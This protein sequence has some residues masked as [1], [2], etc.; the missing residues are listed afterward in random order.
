MLGG[1]GPADAAAADLAQDTTSRPATGVLDEPSLPSN[2][3]TIL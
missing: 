3:I 1:V 2:D